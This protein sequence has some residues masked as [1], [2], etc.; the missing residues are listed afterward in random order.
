MTDPTPVTRDRTPLVLGIVAAVLAVAV[1]IALVLLLT[2]GNGDSEP[3]SQNPG[4][5]SSASAEASDPAESPSAPSAPTES[6]APAAA[7]ITLAATGLS[8]TDDAGSSTFTYDW[9]GDMAGAVSTLSE[10]FG[11]APKERVE[12]GNGS[13]YPDYT[14]Y[15]WPGIAL[16]DMKPLEGGPSR[17]DYS[18]PSYLRLTANDVDGVPVTAEFGV[19]IGMPVADVKALDPGVEVDRGGN[20]R[21]VFAPDRSGFT[22]GKPAY[23]VVVDTDGEKVTAILYYYYSGR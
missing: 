2:R 8:L 17:D 19:K 10:A 7:G 15:Q 12:K 3:A 1:I 16:Y 13:S 21:F 23:S 5:S 6:D 9:N 11:S 14:V 4:G 22:D 18:Q 20:P